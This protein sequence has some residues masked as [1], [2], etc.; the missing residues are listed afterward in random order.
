MV[1]VATLVANIG[2]RVPAVKSVTVPVNW[3]LAL[4]WKVAPLFVTVVFVPATITGAKSF[5]VI[6]P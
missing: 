1:E 5:P 6:N 3:S 2:L 4:T